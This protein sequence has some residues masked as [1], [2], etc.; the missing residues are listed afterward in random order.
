[1]DSGEGEITLEVIDDKSL[2]LCDCDRW[3]VFTATNRSNFEC[4]MTIF[5]AR[6][7]S[8]MTARK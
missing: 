1:M 3:I 6:K 8:T 4:Q 7:F 5:L 2:K